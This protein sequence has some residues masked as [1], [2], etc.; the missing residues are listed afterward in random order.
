MKERMPMLGELE[1][2]IVALRDLVAVQFS[3]RE[4]LHDSG[5]SALT[6]QIDAM[7]TTNLASMKSIEIRLDRITDRVT[8]IEAKATGHG[9]SWGFIVAA[10]GLATG[11]LIAVASYVR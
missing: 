1:A 4:K 6:K 10:G 5:H 11:I 7:N 8:I 3:E 2:K 9:E